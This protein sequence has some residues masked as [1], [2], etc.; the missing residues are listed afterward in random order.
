MRL[1]WGARA[2]PIV[3][4]LIAISLFPDTRP[5]V[6]GSP[7]SADPRQVAR[8]ALDLPLEPIVGRAEPLARGA[9][10]RRRLDPGPP[11]APADE[12]PPG[13]T[14][15]PPPDV[16]AAPPAEPPPVPPPA[17]TA[18][19]ALAA[20]ATAAP[21]T[22]PP[23]PA[24]TKPAPPPAAPATSASA[25]ELR[26][27]A[28]I[29]GSRAQGGLAPYVLDSGISAVARAH[30]GFEAKLGYVYHDGPDGTAAARDGAA[31]GSGWFGENVG[32][33]WNGDVGA[34]H[35]AYMAEPWAPINHRTN[36][37]DANFRRVGIGAAQ[38][39][40]ALYMTMVF[41]R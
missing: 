34:L 40:S 12:P 36:I 21:V 14:A 38:G 33:V 41:C 31:C 4:L 18:P 15:A 8:I 30:S 10:L 3:L 19:P 27:L 32:A 25:A 2:A 20:P 6:A 9:A 13:V 16:T 22:A 17:P 7:P 24:A 35:W 11:D 26:M 23:P 29:N 28:L 5:T 1:R 37:M 39:A